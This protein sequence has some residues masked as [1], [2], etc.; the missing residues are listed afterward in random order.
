[1]AITR[2][3]WRGNTSSGDGTFQAQ[4]LELKGAQL[5]DVARGVAYTLIAEN[6]SGAYTWS[7]EAGVTLTRPM[8]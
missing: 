4:Y 3:N 5:A 7:V 1:M 6:G 2:R 8:P